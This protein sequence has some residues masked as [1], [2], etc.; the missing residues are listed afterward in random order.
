[1]Y[2][3]IVNQ[4]VTIIGPTVFAILLGYV[5]RRLNKVDLAPVIEV[6]LLVATPCLAF[7][8][9]YTSK[10]VLGQALDLW[11][12]LFFV[13]VVT[14]VLARLV[15]LV[16]RQKHSGLYLPIV[17]ANMINIPLPIMYLAFG[18]EGAA[19]VILMAIPQAILV[20]SLGVY[21]ASERGNVRDGVKTVLKT[22][23]IYAAV[24]GLVFN[25]TKVP[26]PEVVALSTRFVGQASVPLMLL[27]L[28]ATIGQFRVTHFGLTLG[29]AFMRMAVGF[30]LGLLVAWLLGLD[31]LVRAV[32]IFESAMP[33]AVVGSVLCLR[34]KNRERELVASVVLVTTLAAVGVVPALLYYLT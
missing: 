9:M 23:L 4:I 33:S 1:V 19:L 16:L 24:V 31:G 10:L 3:D 29:A 15:F 25:L 7:H 13:M 26:V 18:E 5:F 20:Y 14:A 12:S 17:F 28:G 30:G 21:L 11:L 27:V 34:Y 8:S 6:A 2:S 32:V 22:P